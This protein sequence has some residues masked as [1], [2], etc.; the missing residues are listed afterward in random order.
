[1]I[2]D[3]INDVTATYSS[4]TIT[5]TAED[6]ISSLSPRFRFV[7]LNPM[8]GFQYIQQHKQF[9]IQGYW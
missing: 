3:T 8:E 9:T 7:F 5:V 6:I 2:L 4:G 1:N